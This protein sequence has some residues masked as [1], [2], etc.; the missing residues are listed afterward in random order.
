[1]EEGAEVTVELSEAVV[2]EPVPN[3][4]P[5]K[6]VRSVKKALGIWESNQSIYISGGRNTYS[7]A[8]EP[9]AFDDKEKNHPD[10]ADD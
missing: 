1:M 6:V 9:V 4:Y 8:F 5:P 10:A 7:G 3:A 2:H